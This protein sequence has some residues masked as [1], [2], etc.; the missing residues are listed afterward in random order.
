MR[1]VRVGRQ[2]ATEVRV[3]RAHY[4]KLLDV[5]RYASLMSCQVYGHQDALAVVRRFELPIKGQVRRR[6][7]ALS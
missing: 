4:L 5:D 3:S 1:P 2:V 7:V 6:R